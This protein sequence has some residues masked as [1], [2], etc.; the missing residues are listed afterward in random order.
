MELKRNLTLL[1]DFYELT[2]MNGYLRYNLA[3]KIAVFDL[4][5]RDNEESD[6]C[7]A[8]GL[9]Q[10]VEYIKDLHFDQ[11]DL[12]FL[13]QKGGF[14]E[15]FLKRLSEF[16][17][18]GEIYAM[19]EG[20]IVYPFEP[21]LI[22]KAPIFEAQLM[23]SALLC[24]LNFQTLIATK[25]NR[26]VRVAAP[27]AVV[28]FGLRRAQAPDASIYG[29]RAAVIGGCDSTS[30]VLSCQMFDFVPKGTHA[31]SWIMAFPT[32]I[33][34]FRAYADLFPDGCLLLVDTYDTL[35]SGI[36]NAIKVFD[37]LKQKGHKPLGI[38]LDSGDLAYLSKK[39]RIMLDEAGYTD[40]KIFASGDLDEYTI[41]SL[42]IQGSRIDIY[43]VGT[44]L[45]TSHNNPSLGGV[46]K[47]AAI[48]EN[49]K[50]IPKMKVSDNPFKI[51]NP[52]F[53]KVMRLY[54][55]K[56]NKALADVICL[57]DEEIN[58]DAPIKLTHPTDRWKSK[59]ITDFYAK[60][61]LKP[62]FINGKCVCDLPSVSVIAEKT[63]LNQSE[64][65][66]EYT[67]VTKPQTYKVDLSDKLYNLKHTM[68]ENNLISND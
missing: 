43:G 40:A 12:E 21:L 5:F 37:E 24:I 41:E 54:S 20:T 29:A 61:L 23:E 58:E 68:L 18:T 65:W 10:A 22:V 9:H 1:T 50:L 49:G 62:I 7:V 19:E 63:K 13:R 47:L 38:R 56:D 3:E 4:F 42:K 36:P 34:A 64:F 45:I 31:H 16:K 44:Y 26:I 57:F 59:V 8:A 51:T 48:E 55:K 17:F 53:K 33:E 28:E 27:A 14:D 46:Y 30:N 2:M 32:E 6:F 60:N 25:A 11:E 52:G 66:E 67:R 39:A 35:N 15:V